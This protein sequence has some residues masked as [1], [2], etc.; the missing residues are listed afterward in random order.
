MTDEL[1][2]QVAGAGCL[3]QF[4]NTPQHQGVVGDDQVGIGLDCLGHGLVHNINGEHDRVDP[5][6][7]VAQHHTGLVPGLSQGWRPPRL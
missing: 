4:G 6:I 7:R 2:N 5:A 1:G 3:G